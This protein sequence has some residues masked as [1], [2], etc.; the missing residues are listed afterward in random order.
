MTSLYSD[1]KKIYETAIG[2]ALPD[3]A[4]RRALEGRAF[5]DGVVLVAVG[6]AAWTMAKAA[7]D[8]LGADT[9]RDGVV[10]TKYG[11]SEGPIGSLPILEAGH[12]VPDENTVKAAG[13]ATEKVTGLTEKDTVLF[14]LSG[15]GSALF[16]DPLVP[17]AEMA[18]VTAQLLACGAD[19]TEIN[20]IRKR[21][22]GVNGGKFALR[23]APAKVVSIILS[24]VVG[25]RVDMIASGPTVLDTS[26]REDAVS[27]VKKYGLKLTEQA[28]KLLDAA[29]PEDLGNIETLV[30]GSV[31]QL[32]AS[33]K[34]TCEELGYEAHILTD[35]LACEASQAGEFLAA[36][37]R[38]HQDTDRSLALIAGGE[39]VVHLKGTGMGGRNQEM[40]LSAAA[41]IAG[42]ENTAVF[43]VGSDGTDG[44]TDAAGGIVTGDTKAKLAADGFDL[45]GCLANNDAY[46]GLKAAG[47]L[48]VT[49]ATGTNVNDLSVVLIKR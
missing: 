39:T 10:I 29:P 1:A 34:A 27:L 45:V 26:T 17:L 14:L 16:E 35:C 25:D 37:A 21:L 46:N 32:C 15:G 8:T 13:V 7:Y 36:M 28:T 18:D 19:I 11:H 41:G 38:T 24:D 49:G 20:T 23:C 33:A 3:E 6:K 30:V 48:I 44:P 4:V 47:G 42:L 40:A 43:S 31:R 22:S 9:V 12:P 2:A 5:P